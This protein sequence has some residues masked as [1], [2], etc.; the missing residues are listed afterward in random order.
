MVVHIC[1]HS[2]SEA[3]VEDHLSPAVLDQPG[4]HNET[5]SQKKK[6]KA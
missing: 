2:R 3:E 1:G 5:P 4:Q 6:R